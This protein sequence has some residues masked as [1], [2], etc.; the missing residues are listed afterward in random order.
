MKTYIKLFVLLSCIIN[1]TM[2]FGQEKLS[3]NNIQQIELNTNLKSEILNFIHKNK[4]KNKLFGEGIGFITIKFLERNLQSGK[5]IDLE[6]KTKYVLAKFEINI[7]AYPLIPVEQSTCIF[8]NY[9]PNFF[10]LIDGVLILIYNDD[11]DFLLGRSIQ[12]DLKTQRFYTEKSKM[13]LQKL[14]YSQALRKIP[15]KYVIKWYLG[16][17]NKDISY[18]GKKFNSKYKKY[19]PC[20]LIDFEAKEIIEISH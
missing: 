2:T 20:E 5:P 15:D 17:E 8:C 19:I 1:F 12:N 3:K 14:I 4:V 16:E 11:L 9:Y 7:S 6:S 18:Y 10:A 13:K